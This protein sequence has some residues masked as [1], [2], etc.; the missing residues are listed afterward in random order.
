[1]QYLANDMPPD[2]ACRADRQYFQWG[3]GHCA[4]L[5]FRWTSGRG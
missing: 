5:V 1:L 3:L 4:L 2:A